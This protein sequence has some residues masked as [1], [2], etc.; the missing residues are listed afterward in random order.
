MRDK[1]KTIIN[2]TEAAFV[3]SIF[4]TNLLIAAVLGATVRAMFR[5]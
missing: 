1:N 4:L 5:F 2:E 3:L